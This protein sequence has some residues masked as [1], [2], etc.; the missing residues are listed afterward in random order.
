MAASMGYIVTPLSEITTGV[1]GG[2]SSSGYDPSVIVLDSTPTAPI[3][4]R[5]SRPKYSITWMLCPDCR[6]GY[7]QVRIPLDTFFENYHGDLRCSGRMG[8][9]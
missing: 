3:A 4:R 7:P 1:M 8:Q 2:S 5:A 6:A 9:D